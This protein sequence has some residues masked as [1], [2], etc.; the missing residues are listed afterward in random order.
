[1]R[2]LRRLALVLFI[3]LSA[4]LADPV[5]AQRA[6]AERS[7]TAQVRIATV[8][9]TA[10]SAERFFTLVGERAYPPGL[11]ALAAPPHVM[12]AVISRL[13]DDL[14]VE[15]EA[16][17]AGVAVGDE[18]VARAMAAQRKTFPSETAWEQ[19]LL[20]RR[21]GETELQHTLRQ[22]LLRE[23][24]AGPQAPISESDVQADYERHRA[25]FDSPPAL[26]VIDVPLPLHEPS[27]DS[28][29]AARAQAE[30]I[31]AL[32][33]ELT[34]AV[35]AYQRGGAAAR[36]VVF[37]TEKNA[38][39]ALWRTASALEPGAV[40]GPVRA[41]NGYHVIQL[42][43]RI[44]AVRRSLDDARE[45]IARG[46][47][48]SRRARSEAALLARLRADAD[49]EHH[50]MPPHVHVSAGPVRVRPFSGPLENPVRLGVPPG[51]PAARGGIGSR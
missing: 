34:L 51:A 49:I 42:V 44:P 10:I 16:G 50:L 27:P 32:A 6:A 30:E 24:L 4:E 1:M 9:G 48:E 22:Q 38:D 26:T 8:N 31:A 25:R 17:R 40:S 41:T 12:R 2:K 23:Q 20:Q 14:L 28:D 47:R 15:Q 35:V 18:D 29:R 36:S 45:E 13:V 7:A 21:G 19:Y 37:L 43:R 3:T 33:H 39:P 46:L 11:A 5:Q